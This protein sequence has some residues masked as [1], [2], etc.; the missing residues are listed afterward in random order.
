MR[1]VEQMGTAVI[2]HGSPACRGRRDAESQKAHGSFSENRSCHAD[3][4]LDDHWL[5]NIRQNVA[6]D[7][8]KIAGS[9]CPGGF[10]EF[11]LA[12]REDLPADKTRI[13]DPSSERERK[14]EIEDARSTEGDEGDR[15]Q[16]SG[17]REE[18]IHKHD[19]DEAV[20]APTVVTGDGSDD[21]SEGE[22]RQD[23]ATSYEH[24]DARAIDDTRE[25]VAA[26]FVGTE[27]VTV[28][29]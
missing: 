7:D 23:N 27:E 16:D 14:N 22:R 20:D 19:V 29:R 17:E 15:Q 26:K 6:D 5:N 4:G 2:Q 8:A 3:R 11:A 1:R 25:N 24:R 21:Q 10:D 12:R 9:Q 18:G 13:A 28:G